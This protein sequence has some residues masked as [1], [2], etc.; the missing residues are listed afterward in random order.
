MFPLAIC[1]LVFASVTAERIQSHG[2]TSQAKFGATCEDLQSSFHTRVAGLQ[3]LLDAHPDDSTFNRLTQA[4]FTMRTLGVA[5][6]L[7]RARTCSWL[8]N[9][10]SDDIEQMRGIVQIMLAGNPCAQVARAEL[11]AGA[12]DSTV[13]M[14]AVRRAMAALVSD[15]CEATLPPDEDGPLMNLDDEAVLESQIDQAEQQAQDRV[16]ELMD[17]SADEENSGAF[18][19][20]R[21]DVK[22]GGFIRRL[23]VVFLFLLLLLACIGAMAVIGAFIGVVL[24]H[25]AS[26][27]ACSVSY[28]APCQ[29]GGCGV[30]AFM[31]GSVLGLMVGGVAG[32]QGCASGLLTYVL[33]AQDVPHLRYT[34]G[35]N[36]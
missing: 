34:M 1:S 10:D 22:G 4:R 20:T 18:F 21:S 8:V 12:S 11:Q 15:N 2:V 5:R 7:R 28:C 23:A 6:T 3:T 32:L 9:G 17:A 14:D 27:A 26:L 24:I 35:V 19:E 25:V 13:E 31:L 16:D 33:P 30:Q 36:K 29:G